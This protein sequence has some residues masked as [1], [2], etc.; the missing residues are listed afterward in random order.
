MSD[1]AMLALLERSLKNG[2]LTAK[3]DL[4]AWR[5]YCE[6]IEERLDHD[7]PNHQRALRLG[8]EIGARL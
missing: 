4:E 7:D 1:G 6:Q 3:S 8:G 2:E 5:Q